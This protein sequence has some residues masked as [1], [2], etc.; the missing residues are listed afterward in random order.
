MHEKPNSIHIKK[1]TDKP[2]EEL[3]LDLNEIQRAAGLINSQT[4]ETKIPPTKE[5]ISAVVDRINAEQVNKGNLEETI[6]R[7]NKAIKE[8]Q[9]NSKPPQE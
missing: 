2:E 8:A 6:E 1:P 4:K 7:I 5:E 3:N 9:K